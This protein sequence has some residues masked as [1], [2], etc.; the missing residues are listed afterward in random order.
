MDRYAQD[1]GHEV[2]VGSSSSGCR[3]PAFGQQ[4]KCR[5]RSCIEC[6]GFVHQT[7][8]KDRSASGARRF[9]SQA[10][11]RA[12]AQVVSK[13]KE[14]ADA[15]PAARRAGRWLLVR[16]VDGKTHRTS[17]PNDVQRQLSSESRVE[18]PASVGLH[19]AKIA[20][21]SPATRPRCPG[22]VASCRMAADKK[23][24]ARWGQAIVFLDESGFLLQPTV[25]QTWAPSGCTPIFVES[26]RYD[27]LSAVGVLSISPV[28]RQMDFSFPLHA[29]NIDTS[30]LIPF[31]RE[32][33]LHF[34]HRI[35]LI[36]GNLRV[37]FK[38]AKFFCSSIRPG[39][40]L[41][42]CRLTVRS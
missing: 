41:N 2:G 35:V 29:A 33:H 16:F 18:N 5:R 32:L 6:F 10:S 9:E 30:L 3:T 40:G 26:A 39:F 4:K 19:F 17:H 11:P 14:H 23:G 20:A 34:R 7:L 22:A 8:E 36:W 12:T 24:A 1:I 28:R 37:H 38:T 13:A 27:R 42:I 25:R 21:S 31:L 15:N